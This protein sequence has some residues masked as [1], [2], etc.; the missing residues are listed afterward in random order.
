M[1]V[2]AGN[3][4]AVAVIGTI[5]QN[6]YEIRAPAA[7]RT[8]GRTASTSKIEARV[9]IDAQQHCENRLSGHVR[10]SL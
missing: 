6:Q 9:E 7:R 8:H 5:S 10:A 3:T 2:G 1:R 4:L